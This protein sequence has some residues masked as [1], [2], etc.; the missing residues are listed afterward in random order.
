MGI[1]VDEGAMGSSDI[2][3]VEYGSDHI[4]N[5]IDIQDGGG[6]E[7]QQKRCIGNCW[8]MVAL[9]SQNYCDASY[10][11]CPTCYCSSCC[12]PDGDSHC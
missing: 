6:R 10:C 9:F 12:F 1:H 3:I 2:R 8:N 5:H 11:Y 7:M 4:G